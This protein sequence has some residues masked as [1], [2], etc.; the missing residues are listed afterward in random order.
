MPRLTVPYTHATPV[1]RLVLTGPGGA[2]GIA[3]V[4]DSG[5]DRTLLPKRLAADLG[6]SSEDL[7]PTPEGSGGAGGAWFPTWVIPY[8]IKAQVVVQFPAPRDVEP[9]GPTFDLTPE[10]AADTVPLF[11][12]ADFF[13]AFTVTLDQ[14]GGACFHLD[15]SS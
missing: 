11:G 4:V 14:P 6:V 5:A 1:L 12:R 15:Y 10:F 3:G 8:A 9:W 7:E 13:E 2:R